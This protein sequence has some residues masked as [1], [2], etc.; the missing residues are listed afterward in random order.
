MATTRSAYGLGCDR[1]PN[2]GRQW[3]LCGACGGNNLCVGCDNV[4]NSTKKFD[5]CGVCGG[6]GSQCN[7]NVTVAV[8]WPSV[9]A[10]FSVKGLN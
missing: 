4:V 1:L 3:D 7:Q 5:V 8:N 10:N 6:T 2:S 9:T